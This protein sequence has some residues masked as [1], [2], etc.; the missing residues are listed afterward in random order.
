MLT[1]RVSYRVLHSVWK[2]P[3]AWQMT[4]RDASADSAA[5]ARALRRRSW[6]GR[7]L[8]ATSTWC[9]RV[10]PGRPLTSRHSSNGAPCIRMPTA[11]TLPS[12]GINQLQVEFHGWTY[13]SSSSSSI[14]NN[15]RH[16]SDKV[17]L[18][19][20]S[21]V[22]LFRLHIT[23]LPRQMVRPVLIA[24]QSTRR[25][26]RKWRAATTICLTTTTTQLRHQWQ[27]VRRAWQRKRSVPM[28]WLQVRPAPIFSLRE[29]HHILNCQFSPYFTWRRR[30]HDDERNTQPGQKLLGTHVVS[31]TNLAHTRTP[32]T[33][34]KIVHAALIV[35]TAMQTES[36]WRCQCVSQD[37]APIGGSHRSE[38]IQQKLWA[39]RVLNCHPS[40]ATQLEI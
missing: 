9:R 40:F 2:L 26:F 32:L 33:Q 37:V 1:H 12:G 28:T 15:L 39:C 36:Y 24:P 38:Q 3:L 22:H 29:K 11:L 19:R 7:R 13:F 23:W 35:R 5:A 34:W 17:G 31:G 21:S 8:T 20:Q 25:R 4:S 14:C 27:T 16:P 10:L 6:R 30:H 18:C